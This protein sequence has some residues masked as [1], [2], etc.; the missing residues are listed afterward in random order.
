MSKATI[1]VRVNPVL[2]SCNA[3]IIA[4]ICTLV[5]VTHHSRGLGCATGSEGQQPPSPGLL[6]QKTQKGEAMGCEHCGALL[7]QT[8]PHCLLLERAPGAEQFLLSEKR[9]GK[10]GKATCPKELQK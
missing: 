3:E 7:L 9:G 4:G 10:K 8:W 5:D 1:Q 2:I 6:L